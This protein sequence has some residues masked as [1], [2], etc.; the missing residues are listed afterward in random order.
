M[1]KLHSLLKY[2]QNPGQ[3]LN[4]EINSEHYS[5]KQKYLI[6]ECVKICLCFPDKYTVGMSNLG[7]EILYK[8]LNSFDDI[9]C[10]RVFAP[11]TDFE[12]LLRKENIPLMSLETNNELRNFDIIG[13]SLQS[14]LCYS[15]IFT[16]LDLAK[17]S[18]NSNKRKNLFPLIIAGGICT[19]NPHPLSDYI[20][21]FVL[22]E[23]EE[24]FV[25][26][27]DI[28]KKYKKLL[29]T[30]DNL[31]LKQKLL[32]EINTLPETFV[33]TISKT[34]KVYPSYVD[35]KK[36]FYTLK[37]TVPNIRTTQMRLNV[38]LTRGCGYNCNFCQATFVAKPLRIRPP[39]LVKKIVEEGIKSTGY[40]DI[41]FSGF[42][43]TN[44]PQI[45]KLIKETKENFAK[46]FV[47]I[48]LPSLRINDI[49]EELLDALI[50][51]KKSSITLAPETGNE[52]LR[53]VINKEITDY[54]IYEKILLLE[55]FGV[56][57][58][59]LYFMIGLPTETFEDINSIC[60]M[61]KKLRKLFPR[62]NFV[63]TISPFVP[64]PHTPFQFS[65]M[66]TS[67][68]LNEKMQY[69][70][71]S[72]HIPIRKNNILSSIL[73]A[74]LSRGNNKI[75]QLIEQS[76]YDGARF[77]NWT[78]N[79]NYQIWEN[80]IKKLN[81]NLE[82]FLFLEKSRTENFVWDNI[83]YQT[84][85]DNLYNIYLK[86]V[87]NKKEKKLFWTQYIEKNKNDRG[88]LPSTP[89]NLPQDHFSQTTKLR[90]KLAKKGN[91]KFYS[92]LDQIEILQ[93]AIRM[94]NLEVIYTQGFTPTIKM[95][96]G[97]PTPLGYLSETEFIDIETKS[98]PDIEK[99]NIQRNLPGGFKLLQIEII[100]GKTPSLSKIN[101]IEYEIN[102]LENFIF[103]KIEK[104]IN[105]WQNI[106]NNLF[107]EYVSEIAI[108]NNKIKILINILPKK[109]IRPETIL[110]N[111]F[112][113]AQEKLPEFEI[114]RKNLYIKEP[115]NIIK[116]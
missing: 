82:E 1:S 56:R 39:E 31:I 81:I 108:H 47:S 30:E 100:D 89:Q 113:H 24:S 101:L 69:L 95:S 92:H 84:S 88:Q 62:I 13:F 6:N 98:L 99:I 22:G 32:S 94:S 23:A 21:F 87:E 36:S 29:K 114:T 78:E 8:L 53:K 67:E 14:E 111:I 15:N 26:I 66:N 3:Y 40:K 85:K 64:R 79:F 61:T 57:K 73:E 104:I 52:T 48:N 68:E 80:N 5:I 10:E 45:S 44:Y 37:P 65:K 9:L 12:N 41:S 11:E 63:T 46:K 90:L 116:I 4:S 71:K 25:K 19:S 110:Q 109:N 55:K 50:I 51:P 70:H 42:C 77:D 96:Y 93:R 115:F 74:L 58:I 60:L 91:A 83:N 7:I 20:D 43:I 106:E 103:A 112:S 16:I 34:K 107:K 59:K 102:F 38:E 17:I 105:E 35:I 97:P 18:F 72:L 33:P 86:S 27:I 76:W 75:G 28:I 54:E 2:V 49:T